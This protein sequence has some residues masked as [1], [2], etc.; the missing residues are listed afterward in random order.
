LE[1]ELLQ[2]SV[3]P[4][5]ENEQHIETVYEGWLRNA[6]SGKNPYVFHCLDKPAGLKEGKKLSEKIRITGYF[7]KRYQYPAQSGLTYA[8]PMLLGKRIQWFPVIRKPAAAD[9]TWVPYLLGGI[10]LTGISL[11]GAICWF[12]IR[13]QRKSNTQLKRFAAPDITDSRGMIIGR[14][15]FPLSVL[16]YGFVQSV[17]KQEQNLSPLFPVLC[18]DW[19]GTRGNH[20]S[21]SPLTPQP[22]SSDYGNNV[23]H[24]ICAMPSWQFRMPS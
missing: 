10:A 2:L 3:L 15:K 11:G 1:G 14:A 24:E 9:P 5:H 23:R 6:D 20:A 8:A 7:F 12:I 19:L 22:L 21:P 17:V 13:D 18:G 4:K 16:I